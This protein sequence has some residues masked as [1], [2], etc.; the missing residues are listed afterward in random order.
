[1]RKIL[2]L[3]VTLF[4]AFVFAGCEKDSFQPKQSVS[5]SV[6]MKMPSTGNMSRASSESLYS[7]FYTNFIA[8]KKLVPGE[9][10]L[11]FSQNGEQVGEFRGSWDADLI[12]LPEGTY[13]IT[14]TCSGDFEKPSLIFQESVEITNQT[15]SI[16]L[17]A[18]YDC[19]MIFFDKSN[20]ESAEVH[21]NSTTS[22]SSTS[23]SLCSTS[24]IFYLFLP[25]RSASSINYD[26][27]SGDYGNII[28]K[29][30]TFEKGKYYM[31]DVVNGTFTVPPMDQGV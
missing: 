5:F 14:G 28:L 6:S 18:I 31:F 2:L 8:N 17:T 11:T 30:Y 7:D 19:Y 23:V 16:S 22:G 10:K 1:M 3:T 13:S 9:Y 24:D 21:C 27:I 26:T 12:T 25:Y 20:V 15:S 29:N 4:A